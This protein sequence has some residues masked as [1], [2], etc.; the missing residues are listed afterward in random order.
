[1]KLR[2]LFGVVFLIGC[3][4]GLP[5]AAQC[6]HHHGHLCGDC[7]DCNDCDQHCYSTSRASRS[8]SWAPS[9]KAAVSET[10]EGK[11]AEVIYLSGATEDSGMVE[12]RL[13]AAGQ[14]RV[15]RLA[16]SGFLKQAGLLL[17]EGDTVKVKAYPV[18]SME[19]DLLVATE[20]YMG[21]KSLSLRDSRGRPAW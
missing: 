20:V 17:R 4:S 8:D 18:A 2:V 13:Q 12:I 5:A 9:N 14:A 16:P 3:L 1:M 21:D 6:C 11:I 19:G 15:V 10:T 7:G